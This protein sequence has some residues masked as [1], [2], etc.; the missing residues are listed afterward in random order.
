MSDDTIH[1]D[2]PLTPEERALALRLARTAPRGE[3]SSALDARI[4]A[5]AHAAAAEPVEG[6]AAHARRPHARRQRWP[7]LLGYAATAAIACAVAW[8]LRPLPG[9]QGATQAAAHTEDPLAEYNAPP[10]PMQG[11]VVPRK[12][13]QVPEPP[14]ADSTPQQRNSA[15]VRPATRADAQRKPE[16]F[17]TLPP[18]EIDEAIH[19]AADAA[20]SGNVAAAA[21]APAAPPPPAAMQ[22][23]A[24]P[25]AAP[26]AKAAAAESRQQEAIDMSRIP[27]PRDTTNVP[28]IDDHGEPASAEADEEVVPPATADSPAVR[29]AWLQR[30][31]ELQH[32]GDLEAAR[33]SLREFR[34]R[35]P[36]QVVPEDL[37]ALGE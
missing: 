11:R 5:A 13:L 33:A 10:P 29:D 37:R 34:H 25:A 16:A 23:A 12:P 2:A 18:F 35:Y 19:P 9:P 17:E 28:L 6:A 8:Q 21:A 7:A 32:A 26:G 20:A 14:P 27:V 24:A 3:P 15:S 22:R 1:D 36:H 4:L 30:I 31:R